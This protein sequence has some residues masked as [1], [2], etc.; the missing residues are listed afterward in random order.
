RIDEA[1]KACRKRRNELATEAAGIEQGLGEREPLVAERDAAKA[2]LVEAHSQVEA[3]TTELKSASQAAADAAEALQHLAAAKQKVDEVST[4]LR[5]AEADA[6]R[7]SA[8][9]E[10][11]V[12]EL[13][14]ATAAAARVEAADA[15]LAA[16]PALRVQKED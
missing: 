7:I 2:A 6:V 5:L 1:L 3:A 14:A 15:Q 11:V 13:D 4:T 16:L 8:E 12:T 9:R 10:Q